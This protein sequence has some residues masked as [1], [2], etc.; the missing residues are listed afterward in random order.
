MK[1]SF[2][3]KILN[4]NENA[5]ALAI[6]NIQHGQRAFSKGTDTFSLSFSRLVRKRRSIPV[7][8][9]FAVRP[10]LVFK[11]VA[12][13]IVI[14][15]KVYVC[16]TTTTRP[17]CNA[18]NAYEMVTGQMRA[19]RV[20]PQAWRG[21]GGISERCRRKGQTFRSVSFRFSHP[22]HILPPQL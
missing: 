8:F 18:R 21:E 16:E 6:R 1:K 17:L 22:F 4:I 20:C 19:R 14:L 7:I 3:T 11:P 12:I 5:Y 9:T 13:P 10:R 15:S 2:A